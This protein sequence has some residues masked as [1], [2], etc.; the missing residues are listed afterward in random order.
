MRWFVSHGSLGIPLSAAPIAFALLALPITGSAESGASIVLAMTL[1]QVAGAVPV[2]AL[3]ARLNAVTYLRLLVILRTL[4]LVAVPVLATFQAPF[5]ALVVAA[6][7]AGS[8][9]GAAYGY[10]RSIL[11]HLVSD[12]KLPRALGIA[13]TLNEVTA[14]T[15]PLL[16]SLLGA[17]DPVMAVWVLALLGG[18]TAILIPSVPYVHAGAPG[19]ERG[20]LMTPTVATWLGCAAA[21]AAAVS[22]VEIGAV[23]LAIHFGLDPALGVIF[24]VALCVASVIGGV[25]V[26][27]RNRMPGRATVIAYLVAS[28]V[29]AIVIALQLSVGL[30]LAAAVVVGLCLAPLGTYYSLVLDQLAPPDRRPELFSLLRTANA[31]GIIVI[32]GTLATASL[33]LALTAGAVLIVLATIAVAASTVMAGRS[34][35]G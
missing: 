12:A 35:R 30:T 16:A 29:G 1:A 20:R 23:S 26:S 6:A 4:A 10:L 34:P 32:S 2:S 3:G 28:S 11:N 17:V 18:A 27:V 5:L 13:A 14:V 21:N 25:G 7:A 15:A 19:A 31:I 24:P 22:T 8:V 33:A 9:N